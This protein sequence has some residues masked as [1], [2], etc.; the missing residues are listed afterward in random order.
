MQGEAAIEKRIWA[1][2]EAVKAQIPLFR[3]LFGK[4]DSQWKADRSRVTEADLTISR[5]TEAWILETFP[6]DQFFSE[7]TQHQGDPVPITS[8]FV[9][10]IDPVDGTNNFALGMSMCAI[11]LGLLQNG[12]PIYGIIYDAS[13]GL[14]M[15]GG[16]GRVA[17]DGERVM[18]PSSRSESE[19][20]FCAFDGFS[21]DRLFVLL[22]AVKDQGLKMRNVG[23]GTLHLAYT[24]SGQM[25]GSF[26]NRVHVWDIAAAYALCEAVGSEF[27]P[28]D[29]EIFPLKEFSLKKPKIYY[30]AGTPVFCRKAEKIWTDA[31]VFPHSS[32]A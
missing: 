14:I 7:E 19:K 13:R 11:S 29:G 10:I 4:V 18:K 31:G 24:A 3:G 28:F 12:V 20:L 26:S 25:D 6:E 17:F 1:G 32:Q 27:H 9:W 23:S 21:A 22:A 15:H 5:D 8:E 16:K 30:Y 2:I